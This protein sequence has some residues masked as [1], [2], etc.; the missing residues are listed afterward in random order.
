MALHSASLLNRGFRQLGNGLLDVL[1]MFTLPST[2]IKQSRK[3]F[4]RNARPFLKAF[5]FYMFFLEVK[6]EGY[7]SSVLSYIITKST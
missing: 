1:D 6:F 5:I 4:T 3:V 7:S 2:E